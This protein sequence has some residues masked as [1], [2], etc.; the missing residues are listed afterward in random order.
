MED[1]GD[2]RGALL[3]EDVDE[4]AVRVAVALGAVRI[5]RVAVTGRLPR[6]VPLAVPRAPVVV[7]LRAEREQDRHVRPA[8]PVCPRAQLAVE[9]TVDDP[10]QRVPL[11][12]VVLQPSRSVEVAGGREERD[13]GD[14]AVPP[15]RV[16]PFARELE[17]AVP[18]LREVDPREP[19]AREP[20]ERLDPRRADLVLARHVAGVE[21][22]ERAEVRAPRRRQHLPAGRRRLGVPRASRP[23]RARSS[24]T[25]RTTPR[26]TSGNASWSCRRRPRRGP[27]RARRGRARRASPRSCRAP[28]PRARRIASR[29]GIA[30][31]CSIST[32]AA[33]EPAGTA[34]E[35]RNASSS[36]KKWPSASSAAPAI[37]PRSKPS[38]PPCASPI[39]EPMKAPYSVASSQSRSLAVSLATAPVSSLRI[40]SRSMI[41]TTPAVFRRSSSGRISP[42]N[43]LPSKPMVSICTGPK[44]W[45]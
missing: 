14:G 3:A 15:D 20:L 2:V 13:V 21:V 22:R 18:V 9:D 35:S 32:R 27:R 12:R 41:R 34:A 30:H 19:P 36:S 43:R 40:T 4:V 10:L 31:R 26:F 42:L 16:H 39:S 23:R 1:E 28:G 38:A 29:R 25:T 11:L 7:H 17:P 33:D 5:G 8:R 45:G 24:R 6:A 44:T 37:A